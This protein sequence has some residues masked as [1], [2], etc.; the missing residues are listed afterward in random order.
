M[1]TLSDQTG[2]QIG[3]K[4]LGA[5]GQ[6]AVQDEIVPEV[7]YADLSHEPDPA[8]V[9]ER[10]RLGLLGRMAATHCLIELY[11][12]APDGAELRACLAKH[13]ASWHQRARKAAVAPFLW[14]VAARPMVLVTRLGL[15]QAPG[16][17]RGV[18]FF[19]SDVLRVGLVAASELPRRRST[20]LLRLM[21]GGPL[22]PGAITELGE[23]T[24]DAYERVV[25][26]EILLRLHRA[27][28][29]KPSLTSD[30]EEITV[31]LENYSVTMHK[32]GLREGRR[33]GRAQGQLEARAN[34]L[35]T[36][37]RVRG[38][39]VTPAARARICAEQELYRLERWLE[40]AA[41]ESTLAAVLDVPVR[42]RSRTTA[43]GR[44]RRARAA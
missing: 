25:A 19:G 6:T 12:D 32:K 23:L 34:D 24:P 3:R 40:R 5:C 13:I 9:R 8:R 17:P 4:A 39:R 1:R 26:D 2:K 16:W 18:Y 14:V 27:I 15:T 44:H 21:A 33:Q 36:V 20:L 30:E 29:A 38:I 41:V 22:L 31:I 11:S 10:A 28:R 37:L 7:Q 35:L 43:A 42:Q